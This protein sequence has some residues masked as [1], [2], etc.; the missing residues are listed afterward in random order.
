MRIPDDKVD[1]V[2]NAADIVE[3]IG[4]TVRL[5]KRG[6]SYVGL[7]PFHQEKTP[8]FTV[9]PD[10]QMFHCFGCSK[11]GNVFTFVMERD[12]MTFVEAV[13]FLADRAGIGLPV[14]GG[15]NRDGETEQEQLLE[16]CRLAGL[17]FQQNLLHHV[18]G[19]LALEY[20]R[21]RGFTDETI[22]KFGLGYALN[23]WDD[24]VQFARREHL[25]AALVEKAGL[26][27]R[28]ED[29]TGLYDRFRGR[30]MFPIHSASGRTIAFGARKLREDDPLGKYINSPETPVYNKSRVLYGLFQAKEAIREKEFVVLVEGYADLI[31]VAQAGIENIVA[32]SGTALTEEQIQLISR[33]ARKV[34]LVYDADSAGSKATLRGGDLIIERDLDVRVAALPAGEDPDSFVRKNS[35]KAFS[36][37]VE[38]AESFVDFRARQLHAGGF[39]STPEGKTQAIRSLVETIAR[40]PD[41]LKR[42]FYLKRVA[43]EYDVYESVLLREMEKHGGRHPAQHRIGKREDVTRESPPHQAPAV[44]LRKDQSVPPAERDL[45][46]LVLEHKGAMLRYVFSRID[47]ELLTSRVVRRILEAVDGHEEGGEPWEPGTLIDEFDDQE[48]RE[49]VASLMMPQHEL[50]KGWKEMGSDPPAPDPYAIA[51]DCIDLLH[52]QQLDE[53][54]DGLYR[55]MKDAELRGETITTFQEEILVLQKEK[56]SLKQRNAG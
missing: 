27:V 32:S 43:Q 34:T 41:E 12:K 22:R 33:Y 23:S 42:T 7:C 5:K 30:A 47:K 14:E 1:E 56:R 51:N 11:G 36:A 44:A 18:E 13:R 50:S 40:Y 25:D 21:H 53:R 24:M 54:I 35:G 4:A 2:R 20:L 29:N 17:H 9:S 26:L 8:S 3:V 28:R 37:L 52:Q 19:Q 46:R 49:L 16:I 39:F 31:T 10:K 45:L 15:E 6:R 48:A 38:G 55:A